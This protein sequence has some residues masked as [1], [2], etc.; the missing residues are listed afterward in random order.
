LK[1]E[2]KVFVRIDLTGDEEKLL[3]Q[4]VGVGAAVVRSFSLPEDA[5]PAARRP[6]INHLLKTLGIDWEFADDQLAQFIPSPED[7]KE[8]TT[9]EKD[10]PPKDPTRR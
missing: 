3:A 10:T 8:D 2:R 9:V 1:L 7:E 4:L 6:D 5:D